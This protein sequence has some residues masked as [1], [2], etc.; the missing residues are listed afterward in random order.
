LEDR[1][2][3]DD[4]SPLDFRAVSQKDFLLSFFLSFLWRG[5]STQEADGVF[6]EKLRNIA[7][8]LAAWQAALVRTRRVGII[9]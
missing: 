4:N 9:S 6:Y 3:D 5:G 8:E 1:R 7:L 2:G